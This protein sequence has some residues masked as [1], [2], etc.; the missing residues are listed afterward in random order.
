MTTRRLYY[1]DSF[2]REFTARVVDCELLP[3]D[4]NSGFKAPA[5]GLLLDRTAFFP[6]YRRQPTC[7]SIPAS[8]CARPCFRNDM[9]DPRSPFISAQM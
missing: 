8:I 4:L 9:D 6:T 1:D 3:P 5:L 7:S 2:E